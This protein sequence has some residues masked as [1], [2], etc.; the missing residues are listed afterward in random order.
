MLHTEKMAI[1]LTSPTGKLGGGIL[2]AVLENK[3]LDPKDLVV[4]VW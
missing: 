3:F 4:C 2:N 1:A